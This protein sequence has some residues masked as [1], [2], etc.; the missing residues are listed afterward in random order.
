[1][2]LSNEYLEEVQE[3]LSAF[4][5][6]LPAIFADSLTRTAGI[7][8]ADLQLWIEE[9]LGLAGH[10]LRSWEAAEDYFRIGLKVL[11]SVDAATFRAWVIA[12]KDLTE[13][14]AAIAISYFRASPAALGYLSAPQIGES[15]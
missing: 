8:D 11:P 5:A 1:M 6:N 15:E 10:S 2:A 7:P 14:S 4:S 12:G 3:K 13:M 9:G